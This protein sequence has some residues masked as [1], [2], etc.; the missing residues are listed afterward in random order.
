MSQISFTDQAIYFEPINFANCQSVLDSLKVADIDLNQLAD[1]MARIQISIKGNPLFIAPPDNSANKKWLN[2]LADQTQNIETYLPNKRLKEFL[3]ILEEAKNRFYYR[4]DKYQQ[5]ATYYNS[6]ISPTL[7]ADPLALIN[8]PDELNYYIKKQS[9]INY[10]YWNELNGFLEDKQMSPMSE[11]CQLVICTP[12]LDLTEN[13][14]IEKTLHLYLEQ[15]KNSPLSADQFEI[16]LFLNHSAE[17]LQ[18]QNENLK[19]G[20]TDQSIAQECELIIKNFQQNYPQLRINYFKK[21]FNDRPSWG[22][23]KKYAFDLALLRSTKRNNRDKDFFL[24][25]NDIDIIDM[26]PNAI[27]SFIEAFKRS[28]RAFHCGQF[29]TPK[30]VG[31][32]RLEVDNRAIDKLPNFFLI[33]KF[34]WFLE[35]QCRFGRRICSNTDEYHMP[36]PD[37]EKVMLTRGTNS[38]FRASS[39]CAIGGFDTN[40]QRAADIEIGRRILFVRRGNKPSISAQEFPFIYVNSAWQETDSRRMLA[41]YLKGSNMRYAWQSEDIFNCTELNSLLLETLNRET[42]SRCFNE[43]LNKWNISTKSNIAYRALRWLGFRDADFTINNIDNYA[44]VNILRIDRLPSLT[45]WKTKRN[46][47]RLTDK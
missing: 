16:L 22:W 20:K 33:K 4:R 30:D 15:I 35:A 2:S 24:L 10:D 18:S 45:Q 32:G 14:N 12:V 28:D 46:R 8:F 37:G 1:V 3:S 13:N 7:K 6:L 29:S 42:L 25:S 36:N 19:F 40:Q 9:V 39:Y 17:H 47:L 21:V 26:S 43:M 23:L 34:E 31:C 27:Y 11:N 41:S 38:V 44:Q 5:K